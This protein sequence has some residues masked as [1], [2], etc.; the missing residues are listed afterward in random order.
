MSFKRIISRVNNNNYYVGFSFRL[1][2]KLKKASL[3]CLRQLIETKYRCEKS[4][5]L[6]VQLKISMNQ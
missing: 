3:R 1:G 4:L 6:F 2:K 5:N